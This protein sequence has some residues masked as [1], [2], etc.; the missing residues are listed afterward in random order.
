MLLECF[1]YLQSC[2]YSEVAFNTGLTLLFL[3]RGNHKQWKNNEFMSLVLIIKV[4]RPEAYRYNHLMK[5]LP[6]CFVLF[7]FGSSK[8]NSF[9][10]LWLGFTWRKHCKV[11]CH[12]QALLVK[13]N[14][15]CPSVHY[16]LLSKT[17]DVSRHSFI[18]EVCNIYECII[19]NNKEKL[20]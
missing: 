13:E 9:I 4:M 11:F 19:M 3:Y 7:Q 15:E 17:T 16:I 8:L 6:Y 12:F 2:L 1:L 5:L 14:L 18:I 20:I 10:V